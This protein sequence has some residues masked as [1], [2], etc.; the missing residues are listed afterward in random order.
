MNL[1][2]S[3]TEAINGSAAPAK[4]KEPTL[5]GFEALAERT[6]A[7]LTRTCADLPAAR[8]LLAK[9]E[10]CQNTIA[11]FSADKAEREFQAQQAKFATSAPVAIA[12]GDDAW[13]LVDWLDD[14]EHRRRAAL[15]AFSKFERELAPLENRIMRQ[16]CEL[17][18][19]IVA[20]LEAREAA[21]SAAFGQSW[22]PS[23]LVHKLRA[24]FD[25]ARNRGLK[26]ILE[27]T[28]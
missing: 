19:D 26:T 22:E 4:A 14:Y 6:A 25:Y 12:A 11:T 24:T 10:G 2:T 23:W 21:E 15:S 20:K 1:L 27:L 7:E 18:G 13:T 8:A 28:K 9:M 3:L 17:A 16:Y 5:A